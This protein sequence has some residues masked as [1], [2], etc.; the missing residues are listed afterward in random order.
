MLWHEP[1]E[2]DPDAG[3]ENV[4]RSRHGAPTRKHISHAGA[5][6]YGIAISPRLLKLGHGFCRVRTLQAPRGGRAANFSDY[7]SCLQSRGQCVCARFFFFFVTCVFGCC[8]WYCKYKNQRTCFRPSLSLWL[9]RARQVN[10]S[11]DFSFLLCRPC[12]RKGRCCFV[13]VT[14]T[15]LVLASPNHG[16]VTVNVFRTEYL[17]WRLRRCASDCMVR[18]VTV[19][20]CLPSH[21]FPHSDFP[22]DGA[23]SAGWYRAIGSY[24]AFTCKWT[25]WWVRNKGTAMPRSARV[26]SSRYL[27][28]PVHVSWSYRPP[29]MS[30]FLPTTA[31]P[32]LSSTA[33][34]STPMAY[35]EPRSAAQARALR[36]VVCT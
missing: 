2:W 13:A 20:H 31:L 18:A 11:T 12:D 1:S 35:I 28:S 22:I 17:C 3:V 7:G 27:S 15:G 19:P 34:L 16:N 9:C 32:E 21:Q 29:A 30:L 25:R 33:L 14:P 8:A 36:L 5:N 24:V 10:V 23:L 6:E 26:P 4:L